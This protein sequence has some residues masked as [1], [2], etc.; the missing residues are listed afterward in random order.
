MAAFLRI[1]RI[2]DTL[3]KILLTFDYFS[4]EPTSV[5]A[6]ERNDRGAL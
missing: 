3:R 1:S 5:V 2:K 4:Q 6:A